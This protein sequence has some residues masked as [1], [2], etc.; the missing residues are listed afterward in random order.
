MLLGWKYICGINK[1]VVENK[2]LE[3][4]VGRLGDIYCVRKIFCSF[5]KFGFLINLD[6]GLIVW[7]NVEFDSNSEKLI[8]CELGLGICIFSKFFRCFWVF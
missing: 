7:G 6:V 2:E 4:R 1:Y 8:L 5:L 3:Y